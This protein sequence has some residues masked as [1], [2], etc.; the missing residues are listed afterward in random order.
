MMREDH[1]GGHHRSSDESLNGG[2]STGDRQQ[3]FWN[4]EDGFKQD[5]RLLA[6][7]VVWMKDNRR[8]SRHIRAE[9]APVFGFAL[10]VLIILPLQIQSTIIVEPSEFWLLF[11]LGFSL[12]ITEGKRSFFYPFTSR[13]SSGKLVAPTLNSSRLRRTPMEGTLEHELSAF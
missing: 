8:K 6:W 4:G 2:C 1:L 12:E 5:A 9:G 11:C 10:D 13:K 7:V 3:W